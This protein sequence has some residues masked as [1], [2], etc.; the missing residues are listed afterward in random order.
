MEPIFTPEQLA[1]I[2][3]YHLPFY[4]RSAV[5]PLVTLGLIALTLGPLNRLFYRFSQDAAAWLETRL[6]WLRTVPVARVLIQALERLWGEA[7]WGTAILF[8]LCIDLSSKIPFAPIDY[9]F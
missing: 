4:I 2:K 3:A 1:E 8:A 6:G 5:R 7:G 9:Y